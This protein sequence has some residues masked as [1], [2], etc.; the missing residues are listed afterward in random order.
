MTYTTI[1]PMTRTALDTNVLIYALVEPL[2]EKGRRAA[3]LIL[4]L[5]GNGLIP[6]QV[7]GEFLRYTQRRVPHLEERA[8]EQLALYRSTFLTPP[9]TDAVIAAA[10]TLASEH[11][12]Q[13]WDAV[14]CIAA[15]EAGASVLL[16]EDMQDGR[17]LN[18]MRLLNPFNPANDA[19]V[20]NLVPV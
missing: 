10:A 16:T 19:L 15:A 14:I 9:T 6:T 2:S 12:L 20:E 11:R 18:G 7:L 1:E 13:F 17:L 5:A 8:F 3:D 4:K